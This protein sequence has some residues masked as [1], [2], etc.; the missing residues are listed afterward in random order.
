MRGK[1]V[2]SIVAFAFSLLLG[3]KDNP[4]SGPTQLR[5]HNLMQKTTVGGTEQYVIRN[6]R[7]LDTAWNEEIP[8]GQ[9]SSYKTVQSR[10]TDFTIIGEIRRSDLT[11]WEALQKTE[12]VDM[13]PNANN[14]LE[15]AFE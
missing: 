3:C 6:L 14:T 13:V 11:T 5:F 15:L 9:Y 10:S 8:Y 2:L 7:T 4:V 1:I 12:H